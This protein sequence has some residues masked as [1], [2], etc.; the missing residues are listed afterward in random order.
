MIWKIIASAEKY[1]KIKCIKISGYNCLSK[2]VKLN[3]QTVGE[4]FTLGKKLKSVYYKEYMK[5]C[6]AH[7]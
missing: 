2:I 7:F 1:Q 5:V 6:N 3:I 4:F